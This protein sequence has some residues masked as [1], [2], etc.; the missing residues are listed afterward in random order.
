M[1]SL[2]FSK[3]RKVDFFGLPLY[4]DPKYKYIA[5]AS[6]GAVYGFM[7]EPVPLIV[8]GNTGYWYEPKND[9]PQ[10]FKIVADV[11]DFMNGDWRE[12]LI[13]INHDTPI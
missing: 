7:T 2:D 13:K 12:T 9:T 4:I 6:H 3:F 11:A 1:F 8:G 5:M 10:N